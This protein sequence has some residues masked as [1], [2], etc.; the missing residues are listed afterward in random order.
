MSKAF[1]KSNPTLQITTEKLI[2]ENFFSW[3]QLGKPFLKNRGKM[4]YILGTVKEPKETNMEFEIWDAENSM[5]GNAARIFKL[6][7]TIHNTKQWDQSV[8]VYYNNLMMVWQELDLL[9]HFE[10]VAHEDAATIAEVLERD[11]AFDFLAGLRPELDED[12]TMGKR[13]D[14]AE[15]DGLHN[16]DSK[17]KENALGYV[18]KVSKE[19]EE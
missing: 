19:Y 5:K 12:L 7:T 17:T 2:E 1:E 15:E 6:K 11:Q 14:S 4:R 16:L 10:M 8:T 3:S 9:Q 18:S 13:I